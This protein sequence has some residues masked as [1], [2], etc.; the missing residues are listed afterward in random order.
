M[1]R[2]ETRELA[3]FVAVAE[4]LHFGR[5]AQRLGMAQPPLSRAIARLERRLGA[6]LFERGRAVTLTRAGSVLLVEAR[7]VLD[8]VSAAAWRTNRAGQPRPRLVLA[9]K[10]GGDAGLLPALLARYGELPGAAEVEVLICGVGEQ[11]VLLRSGRADVAF[12]HLPYDDP[13]G[14]DTELL[15]VEPQVAVMPVGHRLAARASIEL[16]DLA[17]EP[18]PPWPGDGPP[19]AAAGLPI[20]D[21]GQ[22]LQLIELGRAVAVLPAS[23]RLR[24]RPT[25]AYVPVVDAP[26]TSLVLAWEPQAKSTALADLIAAAVDL[27]GE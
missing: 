18:P 10:S 21:S 25:L 20:R 4:E 13:T 12:L 26:P 23:A 11:E 14:F 19:A 27:A 17:G 2:L 6:R 16:A 15:L 9:T 1:E 5:A 7:R 8:A 3:Y 24:A 22:L